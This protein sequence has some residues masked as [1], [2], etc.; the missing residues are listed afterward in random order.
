MMDSVDSTPKS[1][2]VALT[3]D[4]DAYFVETEG[5]TVPLSTAIVYAVATVLDE[6]PLAL[7]PPLSSILDP[8]SL[9][10]LFEPRLNSPVSS[11][12]FTL[13]GCQVSVEP[14]NR[15]HVERIHD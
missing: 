6:D 5:R 15:I 7:R 1:M 9:D 12:Q 14:P 11:M 8:D 3:E 4:G 10:R 2:D 13:W